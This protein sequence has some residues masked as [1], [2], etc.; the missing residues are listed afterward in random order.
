MRGLA[1]QWFRDPGEDLIF[2]FYV[3]VS[4]CLKNER[5]TLLLVRISPILFDRDPK[6]P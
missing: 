4:P 5:K 6:C 2:S 3:A 1:G